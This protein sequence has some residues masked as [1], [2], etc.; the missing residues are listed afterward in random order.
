MFDKLMRN[1]ILMAIF[2]FFFWTGLVMYMEGLDSSPFI[3]KFV[4]YAVIAYFFILAIRLVL[5]MPRAFAE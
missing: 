4:G 2:F 3:V 1:P 5:P